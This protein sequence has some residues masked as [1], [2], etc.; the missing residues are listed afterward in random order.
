MKLRIIKNGFGK[1]KIQK[2]G[3]GLGRW[4][5]INAGHRVVSGKYFDEYAM[6][7]AALDEYIE[8]K[9]KKEIESTVVFE[10]DTNKPQETN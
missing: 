7:K 1:Y 5:D 9:R 2:K 3:V 4:N 8:S 10:I 6:A